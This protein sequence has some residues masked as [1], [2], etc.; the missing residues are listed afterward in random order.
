PYPDAMGRTP[1]R[2]VLQGR[3]ERVRRGE[4]FALEVQLE[5]M[6]VGVG[7]AVG[8][9]PARLAV[10]PLAGASGPLDGGDAAVQGVGARGPQAYRPD[11]GPVARGQL[12][13]EQLV[14]VPRPQVRRALPG[15]DDVEREQFAEEAEALIEP[16]RV[17]LNVA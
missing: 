7:A 15:L 10:A 4:S 8:R 11:A 2:L 5:S 6:A 16:R 13:R 9:P 3:S 14:V 17:Q 12:E 1:V